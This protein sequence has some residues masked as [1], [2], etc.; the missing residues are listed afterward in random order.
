MSGDIADQEGRPASI[1]S[2]SADTATHE[3]NEKL[4]RL[5][6]S[7]ELKKPEDMEIGEREDDELLPQNQREPE[8]QEPP[9]SGFTSSL[10]WMVVNTLATIGI[11]RWLPSPPFSRN[12][13]RPH[14]SHGAVQT[15]QKFYV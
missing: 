7:G 12:Q 2:S 8:K 3:D 13:T 4:A 14:S 5:D 15:N 10:V 1:S 11:V 6:Q 9:K